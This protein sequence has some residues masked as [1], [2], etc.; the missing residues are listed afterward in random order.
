M[1]NRMKMG[2]GNRNGGG[3]VNGILHVTLHDSVAKLRKFGGK[4]SPSEKIYTYSKNHNYIHI[5]VLLLFIK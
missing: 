4:A 2:P 5:T 1:E 3:A